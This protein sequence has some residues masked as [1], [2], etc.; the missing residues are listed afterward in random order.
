MRAFILGFCLVL[1]APAAAQEVYCEAVVSNE[2]G[3]VIAGYTLRKDGTVKSSLLSWMPIRDKYESFDAE[4]MTSPRLMLHY[5]MNDSGRLAG[6]TDAN[7]VTT[8]YSVPGTGE[9]PPLEVVQID[10]IALPAGRKVSWKGSEPQQ[11]EPLLAELVRKEKPAR[12][13]IKLSERGR[14]TANA[15]FDLA[16][17][18][19]IAPMAVEARA[20]ANRDVASYR[21]LVAAGQARAECPSARG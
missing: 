1:A 7:V 14:V 5:R 6:P 15:E 4:F 9:A 18:A 8:Q 2:A 11:G 16:G 17:I 3:E 13:T 20:R 19:A 10:A 12:L 21:R